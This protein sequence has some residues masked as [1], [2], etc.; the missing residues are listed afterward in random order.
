MIKFL[1]LAL[2]GPLHCGWWPRGDVSAMV[3]RNDH[4][5]NDSSYIRYTRARSEVHHDCWSPGTVN[6]HKWYMTPWR[7]VSTTNSRIFSIDDITNNFYIKDVLP[8]HS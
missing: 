3:A 1:T 6:T 5:I 2:N 4:E 8:H 7:R